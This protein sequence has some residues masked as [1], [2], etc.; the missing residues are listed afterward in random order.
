MFTTVAS[1][2]TISWASPT[3]AR[4]HHRRDEGVVDTAG[5]LAGREVCDMRKTIYE[6]HPFRI[7]NVLD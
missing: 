1:S 7:P 2:T 6:N 3:V 4:V 5:A